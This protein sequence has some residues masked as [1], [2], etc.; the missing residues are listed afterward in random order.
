MWLISDIDMLPLS[1]QYFVDSVDNIPREIDPVVHFNTDLNQGGTCLPSCY[2]AAT[3][4]VRKE[5]LELD[6]SFEKSIEKLNW[7]ENDYHHSP[8]PGIDAKHWYAEERYREKRLSEWI[9]NNKERIY[10]VSRPGGFCS[11]RLDRG[12]HGMPEWDKGALQNGHY[13]DFHMPRPW[14]EFGEQIQKVVDALLS[15]AEV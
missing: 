10:I 15:P 8:G 11:N 3:G 12:H 1:K 2:T 4:K 9:K 14:S 6:P 7:E 13:M 5:F